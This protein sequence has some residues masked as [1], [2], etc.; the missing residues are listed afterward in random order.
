[1]G[2]LQHGL[3]P[4]SVRYS[5]HLNFWACGDLHCKNATVSVQDPNLHEFWQPGIYAT[6]E[7]TTAM[8]YATPTRHGQRKYIIGS[9]RCFVNYQGCVRR[10]PMAT[11]LIAKPS[12][13][14]SHVK[15]A[16]GLGPLTARRYAHPFLAGRGL[17]Q[18]IRTRQKGGRQVIFGE[19]HDLTLR[20]ASLAVCCQSHANWHS[21]LCLPPGLTLFRGRPLK[22]R[23][24]IL[25]IS[26]RED[27]VAA[28]CIGLF[29]V[30]FLLTIFRRCS[31]ISQKATWD[32]VSMR[33]RAAAW[34]N[35]LQLD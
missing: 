19:P 32:S 22:D 34:L 33:K 11:R 4:S 5:A 18:P 2:I 17:A 25:R 13:F 8:G 23:S 7:L 31:P 6:T 16:W 15:K 30:N 20:G 28:V 9:A 12:L 14:C 10:R 21:V 1:M 26:S 24:G 3:L 29:L 35:R 27:G